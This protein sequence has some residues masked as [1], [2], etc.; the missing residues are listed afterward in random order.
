M[1]SML[2]TGFDAPVEGVMYLDRSIREAELLQTIARVNRTDTPQKTA[3]IVVDYYGVAN[4]LTE[5]TFRIP[6]AQ[7]TSK[8]R[9]ELEGRDSQSY[10][11]AVSARL[12][13]SSR[14]IDIDDEEGCIQLLKDE[15]FAGRVHGQAQAVLS[16]LGRCAAATGRLARYAASKEAGDDLR[17]C[18][19]PIPRRHAGAGQVDWGQR[20]AS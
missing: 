2:L 13:S 1:K 18:A 20:F 3:G 6:T 7:K 8:V 15:R 16:K 4:H 12:M 11:T 9:L 19:D 10:A 14:G 17:S 5:S